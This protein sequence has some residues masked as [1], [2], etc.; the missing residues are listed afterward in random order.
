MRKVIRKV[1]V[2]ILSL[3]ITFQVITPIQVNAAS[4]SLDSITVAIDG[5]T[6]PRQIVWVSDIHEGDSADYNSSDT[7]M[8]D[9]Q[10]FYNN[11]LGLSLQQKRIELLT[12]YISG[13]S[14]DAVILGG[15]IVDYSSASNNV[16]LQNMVS[17]IANS[18]KK[19]MQIDADH[20]YSA[21][22]G[23]RFGTNRTAK[24]DVEALDFGEFVILGINNSTNNISEAQLNT[25]NSYKDK[26]VIIA[27][28]VP[29]ESRAENSSLQAYSMKHKG[30]VYYWSNSSNNY[31]PNST[32]QSYLN[33]YIYSNDTNVVQ[34]LAGHMHGDQTGGFDYSESWDGMLSNKVRQHVFAAGFTGKV[35][36]INIVPKPG[37]E[38]QEIPSTPELPF[39]PDEDD[40]EISD[41][42]AYT[43]EGEIIY[44]PVDVQTE[45]QK[46]DFDNK[47]IYCPLGIHRISFMGNNSCV[48]YY[49]D[50]LNS[51]RK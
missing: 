19:V 26:P 7:Y 42:P 2:G 22:S 37:G 29:Y 8:S 39:I 48:C 23:G 30:K 15:D 5:I 24:S 16:A 44:L 38:Q 51:L 50:V 36:I 6:A 47:I 35:G 45:I 49:A 3:V 18:G 31:K 28:H 4:I 10:A 27:T 41:T 33:R 13:I 25:I 32:M 40:S 1:L 43:E 20:D 12:D 9:R 14:A 17:K 21:F 34:V 46:S 11:W